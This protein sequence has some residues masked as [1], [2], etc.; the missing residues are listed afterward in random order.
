MKT[1]A[2]K[3]S[4]RMGFTLIELM[5]AISMMLILMI[6]VN[7]VFRSA[8]T[9]VSTGQKLNEINRD[10]A[11]AQPLLFDSLRDAIK[12][13]PCFII[14]SQ[15]VPQ[16][17][18]AEDAKTASNT[19]GPAGSAGSNPLE[20]IDTSGVTSLLN[21][22]LYNLRNHRVDLLRL[23]V[24]GFFPKR[25]AN[26]NTYN[27]NLSA[28][29]AFIT[30][31]H[32]ALPS[33]DLSSFIAP[34][35]DYTL[36]QVTNPL[37]SYGPT[38]RVGGYAADWVLA[39]TIMLMKDASSV[40]IVNPPPAGQDFGYLR[41]PGFFTPLPSTPP[42][43][44]GG[45]VANMTPLA[46]NTPDSTVM[47]AG[48]A[49]G[50]AL[51]TTRYDLAGCTVEQFRGYIA[52]EI[53]Q[54]RQFT[55]SGNYYTNAGGPNVAATYTTFSSNQVQAHPWWNSLIY[56]KPVDSLS[57]INYFYQL[58]MAIKSP[59]VDPTAPNAMSPANSVTYLPPATTTF[60]EPTPWNAASPMPTFFKKIT[61]QPQLVRP[62]CNPII[63][64]P[65]SAA[66][67]AQM[68]PYFLQHCSQFIVEYAG[69]YMQQDANGNMTGLGSDGQIDYYV[70]ANGNRHIRWY[71]MPRSST[72]QPHVGD[73]KGDLVYIR[74]FNQA[75][76]VAGGTDDP[77]ATGGNGN[78]N[79]FTDV[80]PLRDYYTMWLNAPE[81]T[82]PGASIGLANPPWEVED[83]IPFST[84]GDYG[85]YAPG[86]NVTVTSGSRYACAWYNDMPAMVRI[87]IKVDD[88]NNEVKD[89]P[90]YEYVFRLK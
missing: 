67:L 17:L 78:L 49:T 8:S 85:N 5:L 55:G 34:I 10:A 86:G 84:I 65:L 57:I 63:S 18:N 32:A 24:R 56:T 59:T 26:D 7:Y 88:T 52:Q 31:A 35:T 1:V 27:S 11:S 14:A 61:N 69:D 87:L 71:G 20:V 81:N 47:T 33:N 64:A 68:T 62:E 76:D 73:T 42:N 74:G 30:I 44:Y 79:Y 9:A 21:P 53:L 6:G 23:F 13:P 58:P 48:V 28:Q 82:T 3:M 60:V 36:N 38:Q 19:S 89:G 37:P 16:Y 70:D 12:D 45:Y 2:N 72:G 40:A 41:Q 25:T 43:T 46:Y 22:A 75:Q 39:R 80:I 29:D 90:W 83:N 50:P 77:T 15:I 54:D 4:R 51:S 66:Q